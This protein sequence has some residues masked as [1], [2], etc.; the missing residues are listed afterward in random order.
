MSGLSSS[1][2]GGEPPT[3][4][5][6]LET[7]ISREEVQGKLHKIFT[8]EAFRR[9]RRLQRFLEYVCELTLDGREAEIN[10]F[11]IG[12]EVF[13]RGSGYSPAEDSVVRRQARALREKLADYYAGEGSEDTLRIEV[14]KG[15][16]VPVFRRV[17]PGAPAPKDSKEGTAPAPPDVK[18][19]PQPGAGW[20]RPLLLAGAI[21]GA[22]VLGAALGPIRGRQAP[23]PP[24][25]A[26][27]LQE[28]WAPWLD[29]SSVVICFSNPLYALLKHYP[30]PIQIRGV[31]NL[32]ARAPAAAAEV[33]RYF[34][35][36]GGQ[37]Y[38]WPDITAAKM[39]E[40]MGA[41]SLAA[42]FARNG[43]PV[44]PTQSRFLTW[45]D[46]RRENLIM[47]GHNEQ[48]SWVDP[49]L[50]DY[51]L[52]MRRTHKDHKRRIV[53]T[54]PRPG[55]TESYELKSQVPGEPDIEFALISML[56]GIDRR[57]DL[58]LIGG[59]NTQVGQVAMEFLTDPAG[60]RTLLERLRREAPEH[61]GRWFFQ[62]VLRTE[63]RNKVPSDGEIVYVRVLKPE[64]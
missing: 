53:N 41:V 22:F 50:A 56:P 12:S 42:F 52:Q 2:T 49:L 44:R 36:S 25:M 62:A 20:S 43:V 7:P 17:E 57:R 16:Y 26:A 27:S 47:L 24:A 64:G 46:F 33:R 21:A 11:L 15:G 63:T 3:S 30:E 4:G 19:P 28:L 39:G 37:L 61:E 8:S 32:D 51:P 10:E 60:A 59:L 48:N 38:M 14:P 18:Q 6:S 34:D 35:L 58:L 40:A 31:F 23:A 29:S 5:V 45:E 54:D 9:S 13:E 55:E 1:T